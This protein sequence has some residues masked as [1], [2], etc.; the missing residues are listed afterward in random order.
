MPDQ[1]TW[2]KIVAENPEGHPRGDLEAAL[3]VLLEELRNEVTKEEVL[4]M[5]FRDVRDVRDG[6]GNPGTLDM[7]PELEPVAPSTQALLLQCPPLDGTCVATF[8]P[9]NGPGYALRW[10]EARADEDGTLLFANSR[11]EQWT[12]KTM[13]DERG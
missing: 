5:R 7:A 11:G 8:V 6:G 12:F 4:V 2:A 10:T 9:K 3:A 13:E 1:L